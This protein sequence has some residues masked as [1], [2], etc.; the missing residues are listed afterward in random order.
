MDDDA[1]AD[2]TCT[3]GPPVEVAR[4]DAG[5]IVALSVQG[6]LG[7]RARAGILGLTALRHLALRQAKG[8]DN[9]FLAALGELPALRSLDLWS[10]CLDDRGATG[11]ARSTTLQAIDVR[12]TKVGDDGL[13]ALATL[14]SLRWLQCAAGDRVPEAALV[15]LAR[16]PTLEALA[17]VRPPFSMQRSWLGAAT[18]EALASSSTLRWLSL[19]G[20][21]RTA[22][23]LHALAA[24]RSLEVLGLAGT[25]HRD[26]ERWLDAL[27]ALRQVQTLDLSSVFARAADDLAPLGQM[28]ALRT[29]GLHG[30]TLTDASPG[31]VIHAG[32]TTVSGGLLPWV[33]AAFPQ[34]TSTTAPLPGL[35]AEGKLAMLPDLV[36]PSMDRPP[37]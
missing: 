27:A 17:V 18:V 25:W 33:T 20:V 30:L 28:T 37:A 10:T 21:I 19:H 15:A 16:T 12:A 11:I 6:T 22:S 26:G 14:P 29:L 34:A 7:K 35:R 36:P 9:R 4:D 32:V 23:G 5:Q 1:L 13:A 3:W 24:L 31:A 8:L 2:I